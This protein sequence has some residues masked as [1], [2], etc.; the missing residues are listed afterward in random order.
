ME[1]QRSRLDWL[2]DGDHNTAMFQAKSRARPNVTGSV[3]FGV[4]ME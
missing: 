4:L 2:R 1:R 3:H